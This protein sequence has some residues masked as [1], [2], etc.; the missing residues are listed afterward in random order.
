MCDSHR[1]NC[2]LIGHVAKGN[3][4]I[5]EQGYNSKHLLIRLSQVVYHGIVKCLLLT[6]VVTE[7]LVTR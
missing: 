2:A 1:G 6:G 5:S 7:L 3:A 4:G